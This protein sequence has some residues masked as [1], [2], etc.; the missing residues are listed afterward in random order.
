M[1]SRKD[2]DQGLTFDWHSYHWSYLG[3]GGGGC[4]VRVVSMDSGDFQDMFRTY[5]MC[6]HDCE[7][8]SLVIHTVTAVFIIKYVSS[9][10]FRNMLLVMS[11][12]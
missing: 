10:L 9:S 8:M 6:S 7:I 4:V 5:Y 3:V 2:S 1:R 12:G 11:G